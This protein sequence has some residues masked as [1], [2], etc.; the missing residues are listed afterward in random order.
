M[1]GVGVGNT[2]D[3][4]PLLQQDINGEGDQSRKYIQGMV[5]YKG[6]KLLTIHNQ[7]VGGWK[8]AS[9]LLVIG[10]ADAIAFF[11]ISS[12]LIS[13]LT[14]HFG[15]STATAALNVNIWVGAVFM[16]PLLIAFV[17]DS[18]IG[19][20]RSILLASFF[21]ILGLGFLTISALNGSVNSTSC[22]RS[23]TEADKSC[24]HPSSVQVSFF[25][26]SLYL[27]AIGSAGNLSCATA[28]GADQF[29]GQILSECKSR[30]SFFTWGQIGKCIG[31]AFS[32]T[33]LNYIQDNLSWGLGFGIS[34]ILMIVALTIFLFGLKTYRYSV[35]DKEKENP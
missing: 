3:Y 30:S 14:N 23:K 13:Y 10:V 4:E 27:V 25:F 29:D 20:F 11:G 19:R 9:P 21:E 16:L 35:T 1:T 34:C 12:N 5:N 17:A 31:T 18:Y 22:V 2:S 26:V 6:E 24:P 15:Q 7:Q 33:I 28:F 8:S 32:N